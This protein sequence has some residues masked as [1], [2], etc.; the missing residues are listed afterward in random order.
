MQPITSR[1][2]TYQTRFGVDESQE[3]LLSG[4]ADL[5]SKVERALFKDLYQKKIGINA[6]KAAYLKQYGITARQFNS[7]R[8]KLEGKALAYK[9]LLND[10]ILKLEQKI[11]GLD[12][13]VKR[14][15]DPL[16]IHQKKRRLALLKTKYEKLV[17][18][19]E[20]GK[21]RI[22][23]GTKELFHKQ[24]HLEENGFA[25]QAEWKAAWAESR[26]RQFFLV[27][28]KDETCGNQSCQ[29][30]KEGDGFTLF[31][32]LPNSCSKKSIKLENLSFGYGQEEIEQALLDNELRRQSKALKKPY[33]HLGTAINYLFKKD[34]KSWR[35]FVTVEKKPPPVISQNSQG[36][37]GLDINVDR[38]ALAETD[39]F[40]NL[41]DKKNFPF[42]TY[43]KDTNQSK[44][45]IGDVARQIAAYALF[46][47]KPLVIESLNFEKKKQSL[48]EENNAYARM[49]SSFCYRQLIASIESRAFREGIEVYEVN[50][51][52]TSII[53]RT[54][55]MG[56]YGLSTHISAALV[57]GRRHNNYSERLPCYLEILDNKN[58]RSAFFLPVRNRKKHV[59]SSYRELY[60][61]ELKTWVWAT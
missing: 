6:L 12:K 61:N 51:A 28:S 30:V 23:F 9:A 55:F 32:R 56:R 35:V 7:C 17:K 5:L 46:K 37:I 20:E 53:G 22:C 18:D 10:R 21:I 11:R 2:F 48:R 52:F 15:K 1:K 19:K 34:Q 4:A 31:V 60:R 41:I 25:T 49:L 3:R 29:L 43:G 24:F 44:A 33:S 13:H 8:I 27:G 47:K 57:I 45:V 58:S 16:K 42:T 38:V 50:P 26:N 14:S 54:K 36:V 59:W 39:R 40:G